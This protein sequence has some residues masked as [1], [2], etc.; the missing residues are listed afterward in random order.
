MDPANLP[1]WAW[2]AAFFAA[3]FLV[4]GIPHYVHGVSGKQFPTPFSGG[5]GTLDSAVRNVL[6]G[7]A[8]FLA[9]GFLLWVIRDALANSAIIGELIVVAI[10]GSF[11][12]GRV[13][14]HPRKKR[15]E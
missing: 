1:W 13:F 7:V 14:S 12:L 15:G 10:L 4:N 11:F 6:W 9:G 3:L 2:I 8:N 5:A